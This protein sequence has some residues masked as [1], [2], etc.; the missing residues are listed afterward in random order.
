MAAVDDVFE[1]QGICCW[2][3]LDCRCVYVHVCVIEFAVAC[4]NHILITLW[5]HAYHLGGES[6]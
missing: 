1:K 4:I 3:S 6:L 5:G 2:H